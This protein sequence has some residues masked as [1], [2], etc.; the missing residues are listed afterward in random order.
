MSRS[1]A[2]KIR[3]RE[4]HNLWIWRALL[5]LEELVFNCLIPSQ[6]GRFRP[7]LLLMIKVGNRWISTLP[8]T[9]PSTSQWNLTHGLFLFSFFYFILFLIKW[10]VLYFQL[11]HCRIWC[12]K[13]QL[14]SWS[15]MVLQYYWIT[16][17]ALEI[18]GSNPSCSLL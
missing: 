18:I 3:E 17:L 14:K 13:W 1:K 12:I 6:L 15:S 4:S 10:N 2:E 8:S 9:K 5:V 16:R 7:L 11:G